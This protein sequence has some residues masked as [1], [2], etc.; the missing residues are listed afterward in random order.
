M[1]ETTDQQRIAVITGSASGMGKATADLLRARG[2]RV[3]GV[4]LRNA[5]II[6]DLS[7]DEG[8]AAMISQVAD[9][10]GDRL[11][12]V[13]ANAGVTH[14][15]PLCYQVNYFGA[16]ATLEGLR[17]LLAKS[18][19][20]RAVATASLAAASSFDSAMVALL[21]SGQVPESTNVHGTAYIVSKYALAHWVRM[22]APK[23]EWAGS[24]ILLNAICPGLIDTPMQ[25]EAAKQESVQQLIAAIPMGRMAQAEEVAEV[26]AFLSSPQNS[27]M[28]GQ[29]IFVD[30]ALDAMMRDKSI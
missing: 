12:I 20:P 8:R 6:A 16:L 3:I 28:A 24:G 13:I 25:E 26:F 9:I 14:P 18:L 4:D 10:A 5:D 19:A 22:N 11:D 30:G 29:L 27:Y 2:C 1:T 23:P 17:P 15:D 7:S 21:E